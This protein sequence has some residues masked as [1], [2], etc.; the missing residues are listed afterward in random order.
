MPVLSR[1]ELRGMEKGRQEGRQEGKLLNARDW[2]V[3][4]LETRFQE[5]PQEVRE[6]V[7]NIEDINRLEELMK[8]AI[9][10]ASVAEFQQLVD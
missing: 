10:I 6:T 7:N 1:M 4:V 8:Q 2:V 3:K 9:T 5:V